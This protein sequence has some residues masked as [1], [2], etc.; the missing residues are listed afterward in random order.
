MTRPDEDYLVGDDLFEPAA[1]DLEAPPDDVYEQTLPV[2]P[3]EQPV[4][5][6]IP[7][8]VDEADALEQAQIIQAD[9]DDR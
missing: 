2:D 9:D 8:E 6:R 3:A 4:D 1:E 5:V 7:F